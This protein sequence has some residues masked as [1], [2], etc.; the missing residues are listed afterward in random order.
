MPTFI[1]ESNIQFAM[2]MKLH[3]FASRDHTTKKNKRQQEIE[4][5]GKTTQTNVLYCVFM[6]VHV[7]A[8]VC[9]CASHTYS[10]SSART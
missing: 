10:F 4:I 7:H 9:V 2:K 5:L 1:V 3:D 6:C 8:C